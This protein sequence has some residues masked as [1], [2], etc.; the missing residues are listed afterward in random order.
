MGTHLSNLISKPDLTVGL[1]AAATGQALLLWPIHAPGVHG[2]AIRR[3]TYH[4]GRP[5]TPVDPRHCY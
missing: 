3:T 1:V 5:V 2:N 4:S